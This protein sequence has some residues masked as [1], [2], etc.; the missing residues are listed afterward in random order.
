MTHDEIIEIIKAHKEGKKIVQHDYTDKERVLPTD[1]I[2][3][4]FGEYCYE[5][6]EEP[7]PLTREE[8]TAKWVKDNDA[9]KGDIVRLL[10]TIDDKYKKG[11]TYFITVIDDD[12]IY[13]NTEMEDIGYLFDVE[14]LQ[15]VTSKIVK[16]A[17]EDRE[18]F[19]GK[20]VRNKGNKIE[21]FQLGLIADWGVAESV[22]EQSPRYTYEQAL[23]ELEF[24]DG[25]PF[26]KEIWE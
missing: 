21:E 16:F 9:K 8:I 5:I 7:R 13:L 4:N 15:K 20:W 2:S 14:D 1:F 26:S 12:C 6:M 17:F 11:N 10:R 18:E 3:W 22:G 25:K 24:I 19:R 23:E